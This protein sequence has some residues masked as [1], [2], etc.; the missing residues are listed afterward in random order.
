MNQLSTQQLID[1]TRNTI[2]LLVSDKRSDVLDLLS[3]NNIQVNPFISKDDLLVVVIKAMKD[4][5]SFRKSMASLIKANSNEYSN[6]V[7][8]KLY[9]DGTKPTTTKEKKP[10]SDTF[11]GGIFTQERL[12][13]IVD[14]AVGLYSG[15]LQSKQQRQGEQNA[16]N[17][18]VAQAN[19]FYAQQGSGDTTPK[20]SKTWIFVVLGV[21]LVGGIGF[22]MYKK[23]K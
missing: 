16:I 5:A 20:K 10:F 22:Y 15:S 4:S 12:G 6:Y 7:D 13:G 2:A 11:L 14:T 19:K 17:Y 21:A 3:K 23:R 8:E 1:Y 18:E 9:A